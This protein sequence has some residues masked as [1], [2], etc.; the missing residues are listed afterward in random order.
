MPDPFE[1]LRAPVTPVDP[2]PDFAAR[3]RARLER[4]LSLPRGVPVTT[5]DLEPETVTIVPRETGAVVPYLA[6]ADGRR[7]IDWYVDVLG[8]R[9]RGEPI[10]MDDGR[11]GHA[12][13]ELAGGVLYLAD[14]FPEIGHVAPT[15][16]AASVSLV[17]E[18]ADVDRTV[19]RAVAAGAELTR[20]IGEGHGSRNATM[21]DPF[22]HRWMLQTPLA[23]SEPVALRHGDLAYASLQVPD[24]ERAAA[25]FG[26]VLGWSFDGPPAPGHARHVLGAT[27][28]Q[29]V[30][31]GQDPP[32]LFACYAVDDLDAA[33]QRVEDAGGEAGAPSDEP[34][35]RVADCVDD[36]G[37]AFALV[38]VPGS[39]TAPM[40]RPQNGVREGDLAYVTMQVQDSARA[41]AFYGAVLGWHFTPGRVD[42]GWQIP[43]VAP[44]VG[45]HGGHDRATGVPMFRVDDVVAAVARVRATGGTATDPERQ[46]YGISSECVDDQGT[47]FFLGEL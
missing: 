17:L 15:A 44:M 45:M 13:L 31:G 8:A 39:A 10:V 9:L 27:P 29:G 32:T 12:E 23:V 34:H 19:D 40:E 16:G 46:P 7:A 43:D 25:F 1:R 4:A 6:V 18:V 33:L 14:S 24:G 36:Q 3:L 38:E 37:T 20:E 30:F 11:V 22:G 35:G 26:A 21:V 5:I 2:G 47:R 28:A 42:D 41:R